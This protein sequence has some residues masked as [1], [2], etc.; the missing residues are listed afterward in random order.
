[1]NDV[2]AQT[3]ANDNGKPTSETLLFEWPAIGLPFVF[4]GLAEQGVRRAKENSDTMKVVSEEMTG[5]LRESYLTTTRGAADYNLKVI[6]I[7]N[8]NASSAFD[9]VGDL[10][11][12][13]SMTDMVRLSTAHARRSLEAASAQNTEL[14]ELVQ[15]VAR[16]S[17]EPIRQSVGKALSRP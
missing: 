13:K 4:R 17:A 9:F 10:M 1:M 12:T 16:E 14:W 15:R 5:A 2:S 11:T 8:A 7:A 6:Q 3:E